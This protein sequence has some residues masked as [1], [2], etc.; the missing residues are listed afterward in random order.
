MRE[1]TR[2]KCGAEDPKI[3]ILTNS[4]NQKPLITATLKVSLTCCTSDD[5]EFFCTLPMF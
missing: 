5:Q 4:S 1:I 2:E 3:M